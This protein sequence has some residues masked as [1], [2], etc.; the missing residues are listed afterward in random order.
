MRFRVGL[1]LVFSACFIFS[2]CNTLN[3]NQTSSNLNEWEFPTTTEYVTRTP[4]QPANGQSSITPDQTFEFELTEMG[5]EPFFLT[6]TPLPPSLTQP[7]VLP[8][9][10]QNLDN[11][12]MN[13]VTPLPELSSQTEGKVINYLVIG[14]DARGKGYFRTDTMVIVSIRPED[15]SVS[16][17]SVPRDL[18]VFIPSIGMNK[19][20][21]AYLYGEWKK[22]PGGGPALLR[23]TY[24]QNLGVRIDKIA[25]VDF[26]GFKKIIDILGGIDLPLACPY[27]DWH[28]INPNRSLQNANNWKL[29]TVGPGVVH[30][31][32]ELALW[33][34]RSRMRSNDYDRGRR[35]QEVLRA[36]YS[37]A[38]QLNLITQIPELFVQY[39]KMVK[40]DAELSDLLELV[41]LVKK[42]G[43]AKIRSY[44]ITSAMVKSTFT[45]GGMFVLIPKSEKI[46]DMLKK[47]LAPPDA[48]DEER[49][50][51]K[52]EVC[53]ASGKPGWE[54]LAAERLHYAG[55]ETIECQQNEIGKQN[56]TTILDL[57]GGQDPIA[58][59]LLAALSLPTSRMTQSIESGSLATFRLL[60]GFDYNTCFSP[61]Q[62]KH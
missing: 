25:I 19:I 12:V 47:A 46:S 32:G 13:P 6:E 42:L 56:K 9:E 5:E 2:G 10:L 28:V 37:K 31:D 45:P 26:S 14:S 29:Y 16:M 55:F 18:Y 53:N 38:L 11:S 62:L 8:E 43:A 60:L 33:Y 20:N 1:C 40:T 15:A 39:R 41:P 51:A 35:Q 36:I 58:N 22:Y 54:L 27:T 17:I 7:V 34:A 57:H 49:L 44:Y 59:T 3:I 23:E 48:N 4:F 50:L 24:Q 52:V 61:N 30:M 21:T